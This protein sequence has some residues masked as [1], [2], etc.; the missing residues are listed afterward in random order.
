[1]RK[2]FII[3][4]LATIFLTIP[5][6]AQE[7]A[8]TTAINIELTKLDDEY[9]RIEKQKETAEQN[10]RNLKAAVYDMVIEQNKLY[11]KQQDLLK[12]KAA[13]KK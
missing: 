4:L 10:I 1:M 9:A 2:L 7:K 12:K 5:L 6:R 3:I 11:F 8:D 13:L